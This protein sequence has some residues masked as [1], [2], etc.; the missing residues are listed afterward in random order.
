MDIHSPA[1]RIASWKDT[2]KHLA[3][4][5]AGV[6]IALSVEGVVSWADHR[7]LVREAEGNLAAELC[8]NKNELDGGM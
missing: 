2:V 7:M 4:I 3:I 8:C 6:L 1:G 5:T